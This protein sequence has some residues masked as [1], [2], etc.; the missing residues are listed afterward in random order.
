VALQNPTGL[1]DAC[2]ESLTGQQDDKVVDSSSDTTPALAE[3]REVRVVIGQQR[4]TGK[5][6][7][8]GLVVESKAFLVTAFPRTQ[9][10]GF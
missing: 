10:R 4:G 7:P 3:Q 5:C 8:Q 6:L 1:H 9:P 2:A